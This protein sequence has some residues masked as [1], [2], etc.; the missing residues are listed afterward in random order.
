MQDAR[1]HA[2]RGVDIKGVCV[3]VLCLRVLYVRV[4]C[5]RC[6]VQGHMRAGV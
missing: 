4:L 3:M 5:L 1:A 6:R 2:C